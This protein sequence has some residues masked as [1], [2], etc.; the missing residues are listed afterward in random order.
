MNLR[1]RR[2][3]F[4]LIEMMIVIT[5]MVALAALGMTTSREM[6]PRF[7]ARQAAMEFARH[8]EYARQLAMTERKETRVLMVEYDDKITSRDQPEKGLY[9]VQMGNR[10]IGSTLWD[11]LPYE[12]GAVDN[13][14]GEGTFD[15]S[16]SGNEY[17]KGVSLQDWGTISGPNT[18]NSD[19]IVF[20][21]RGMVSN[22][23]SD[24]NPNYIVISFANKHTVNDDTPT[25]Y[26]NVMVNRSW[27]VRVETSRNDLYTNE[28][29][30]TR[31]NTT[32]DNSNGTSP[33]GEYSG[34]RG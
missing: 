8:V 9:R 5:V 3:A 32:W 12:T 26:F 2:S 25:E 14:T 16:K 33:S 24:F 21:P 4:T 10:A 15:M 22:P 13:F 27:M 23:A 28:N 34:G 29:S 19:A 11:T 17:R 18:G 7:K 1:R 6:I 30:G 31:H 20:S